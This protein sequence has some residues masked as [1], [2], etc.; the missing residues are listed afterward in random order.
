LRIINS[1]SSLEQSAEAT[2]DQLDKEEKQ[3]K[4]KRK[5]SSSSS[6]SA[7]T[8]TS[9]PGATLPLSKKNKKK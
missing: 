4:K 7:T 2:K 6:S 3:R 9:A 8:T 1:T 5:T